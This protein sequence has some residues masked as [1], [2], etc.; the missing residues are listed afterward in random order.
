MMIL[1]H[2]FAAAAIALLTL[3]GCGSAQNE[4][5]ETGRVATRSGTI[6]LAVTTAPAQREPDRFDSL[7][8]VLDQTA[9]IAEGTV[10]DIQNEYSQDTGPWTVVTLSQVTTH[11]GTPQPQLTIR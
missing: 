8:R 3:S 11:F 9:I 4:G 5:N 7:L 6:K 10:S 2:T 1:R